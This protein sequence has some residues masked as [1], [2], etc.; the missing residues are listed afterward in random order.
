MSTLIEEAV[1]RQRANFNKGVTRSYEFR[2]EQLKKLPAWIHAHEQDIYDALYGDL[3]KAPFECYAT[4][5]GSV[6]DEVQYMLKHL[7]GWMKPQRVRTPLTQFPSQCF[8]LSEPYG[9]VLIMAPWNYPFQLSLAPLVGALAAGNCAVI[10]PCCLPGWC[11]S[12][13]RTGW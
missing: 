12:F 1:S 9:V 3:N 8:R 11:A 7:Q 5:N 4:E 2:I 10:K 13:T 6:L